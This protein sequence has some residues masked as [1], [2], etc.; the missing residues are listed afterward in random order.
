[1][2]IHKANKSVEKQRLV[3]LME[4]ANQYKLFPGNLKYK[5]H[6]FQVSHSTISVIDLETVD[7]PL[8]SELDSEVE[9]FLPLL[10][11]KF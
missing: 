6:A 9:K 5:S 7:C 1:M 11:L 8:E 4:G 10:L 2:K 3:L